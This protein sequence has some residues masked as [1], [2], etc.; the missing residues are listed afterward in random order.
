MFLKFV[1]TWSAVFLLTMLAA[2][3]QAQ[4][5]TR[6]PNIMILATGG[7]IAVLVGGAAGRGPRCSLGKFTPVRYVEPTGG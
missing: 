7:T 1:R 3:A 2:A 4:T 5:A 6:L